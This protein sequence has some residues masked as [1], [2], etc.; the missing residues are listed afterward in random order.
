MDVQR[1]VKLVHDHLKAALV[2]HF[3]VNVVVEVGLG[4]NLF[5]CPLSGKAEDVSSGIA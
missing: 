4:E 1:L 5:R 3:H 2:H